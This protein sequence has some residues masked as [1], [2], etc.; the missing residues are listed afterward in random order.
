[1]T[2]DSGLDPILG[3]WMRRSAPTAPDDLLGRVMTEVETMSQRQ[4]AGMTWFTASPAHIGLTATALVA[5]LALAI[6]II[7]G[8]SDRIGPAP[9]ESAAP[10]PTVTRTTDRIGDGPE[11][12]DIVEV[13]TSVTDGGILNVTVELA[14]PWP[15]DGRLSAWFVPNEASHSGGGGGFRPQSSCDS[16]GSGYAAGVASGSGSFSSHYHDANGDGITTQRE[17][18]DVSVDGA[19]VTFEVPLAYLRDPETLGIGLGAGTA[20]TGM[21]FFPD[22]RG[23]DCQPVPLPGSSQ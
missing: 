15:D 1:M 7:I 3:P 21:D 8:T 14:T 11:A 10:T 13:A 2:R 12:Y 9:S 4:T 16:M 6:G 19:V 5:G 18:L 20:A 23:G 17:S 22:G